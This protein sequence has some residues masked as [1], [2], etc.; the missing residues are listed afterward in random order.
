MT[1]DVMRSHS[2]G[3]SYILVAIII[4]SIGIFRSS[5]Y[6]LQLWKLEYIAND[7]TA[8]GGA[9]FLKPFPD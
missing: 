8:E 4:Q 9:E 5:S 7:R 2:A 3:L 6:V 1:S